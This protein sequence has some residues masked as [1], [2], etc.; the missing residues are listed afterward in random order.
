[1]ELEI[2]MVA[3]WVIAGIS[4]LCLNK[5]PKISYALCWLTLMM[6]MIKD[7]VEVFV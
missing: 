1:M 7:L 6:W 4:T 5:V 2:I 3:I